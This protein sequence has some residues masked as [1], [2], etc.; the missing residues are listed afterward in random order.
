[1]IGDRTYQASS[2]DR[3]R[4]R[5]L[6]RRREDEVVSIGGVPKVLIAKRAASLVRHL[7]LQI[8]EIEGTFQDST[9]K[10]LIADDGSTL[11]YITSVVFAGHT[12][13]KRL[14]R[15]PAVSAHSLDVSAADLTIVGA[16]LLLDNRFESAGFVMVPKWIRLFLPIYGHPDLMLEHR[17][18]A[19]RKYFRRLMRTIEDVG[20]TSEVTMDPEWFPTFYNEMYRPYAMQRY[21]SLAVVHDYKEVRKRFMR[22]GGLIVKRKG[23]PVGA[24]ILCP[25]GDTLWVPHMGVLSGNPLIAREGMT[26]AMD[27]FIVDLAHRLGYSGI[28]FGHARPFVTDGVLRYKLTWHMNVCED[29]D[30]LSVFAMKPNPSSEAAKMFL[31]QNSFYH[32]HDGNLSVFA[33]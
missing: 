13:I 29:D 31:S 16:N 15:V 21:G 30:A 12:T 26:M 7:S 22:G 3:L 5:P 32:L 10:V 2:Q 11:D 28:N 19:T 18:R 9:L 6:A 4:L 14:E 23:E 1:M 8:Y 17:D 20:Y 25:E 33:P 24:A 27:Y